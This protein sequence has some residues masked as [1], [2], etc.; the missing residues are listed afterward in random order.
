[1]ERSVVRLEDDESKDALPSHNTED[2][3]LANWNDRCSDV[4]LGISLEERMNRL[5]LLLGEE[6]RRFV[7]YSLSSSFGN[8]G[9]ATDAFMND[10]RNYANEYL[11]PSNSNAK[12]AAHVLTA[13][14]AP[15]R[16][17]PAE[18]SFTDRCLEWYYKQP[19]IEAQ[20]SQNVTFLFNCTLDI[21]LATPKSVL[22]FFFQ[23]SAMTISFLEFLKSLS[24]E[25][26][27]KAETLVLE[28]TKAAFRAE[29]RDDNHAVDD[30]IDYVD[31]CHA[32]Y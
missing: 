5:G 24:F 13:E 26:E 27:V 19:N 28:E 14:S 2:T 20:P 23:S 8:A 4:P 29:Y 10:F 17:K 31:E 11:V 25:G 18:L 30:F 6:G 1:M 12:R 7:V 15:K 21:A 22:D 3:L 16:T 9:D 32:E